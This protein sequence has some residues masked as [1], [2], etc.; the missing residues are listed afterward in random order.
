MK[1]AGR[2]TCNHGRMSYDL[3]FWRQ[4]AGTTADPKGA[5]ESLLDGASVDGLAALPID[6]I[7]TAIL[8]AFPGAVREPNGSSEWVIWQG[9]DGADVIEVWWSPQHFHVVCR[10]VHSDDMNTLIEIAGAHGC[11]LFDPQTG[12]R[13]NQPSET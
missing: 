13:F 4:A 7:L 6:D 9:N 1:A 2:P 10:H 5:Y 8:A 12:E 3:V 11:A